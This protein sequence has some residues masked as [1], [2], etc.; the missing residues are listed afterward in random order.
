MFRPSIIW[1]AFG[2]CLAV[3]VAAVGWLSFRALEADDAE[4][5]A[6]HQAALEENAQLALWRMDSAMAP[7][8]AQESARPYFTY[9]SFYSIARPAA[10]TKGKVQAEARVASPLLV[11]C[12]PEVLLH[13][14][15][16]PNH[17]FSSPRVPDP[18]MKARA[19][20]HYLSQADA[21]HAAKELDRV[22]SLIQPTESGLW[23]SLPS[24]DA[25]ATGLN[26]AMANS[27][28]WNSSNTGSGLGG[29]I[30]PAANGGM[31]N[32]LVPNG[33]VNNGIATNPTAPSR[34]VPN[35][36][37]G[38]GGFANAPPNEAVQSDPSQPIQSPL[39]QA[40]TPQQQANSS[41]P[42]QQQAG[43]QPYANGPADQTYNQSAAMQQETRGANEYQARSQYL[44]QNFQAIANNPPRFDSPTP[45]VSPA[46][47]ARASVMKP[48]WISDQLFLMRRVRMND[49]DY[50]QGCLL[51]W[52]AIQRQLLASVQDLLPDAKLS[53]VTAISASEPAHMLASLPVRLELGTLAAAVAE[54]ISPLR[55]SLVG[56]WAAMVLAALAVAAL[57]Q[58][59]LSLSERR[60]A[61]V[62]AVTHE[63]RTPLTT[64]RMYA[65]MLASNMVP[66]EASRHH[67]LETLRVEADRLTHLV[68]NV[69]LYARLERG[70]P[71]GRTAPV[72]VARI[73]EQA[74][75]RLTDRARQANLEIAVEAN[76][77]IREGLVLADLAAVEQILFNLVDNACKYAATATDRTL[78]LEARGSGN[79]V[80]LLLRD[81][82]PGIAAEQR[83]V[84][85]QP[86]R[87]SARDAA[88]SAPGVGLG[89]AL[90]RRLARDMGGELSYAPDASG[91]ACFTLRL[92]V[93]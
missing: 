1:L 19:I 61:F 34:I 39:Q 85:F 16:G 30:G 46:S 36:V 64:F 35:G 48:L 31:N 53:P 24:L 90:C 72:A 68:E 60:G 15:I 52:P 93:A 70:R 3:V 57:L 5:A 29:A 8:V 89:L 43:V 62:S 23:A 78:H 67:Y 2:V 51:D 13:F 21:E 25:S 7:L 14:Q 80:E 86:F 74:T 22:R 71:G 4:V 10:P 6:R 83:R 84:L 28:P 18:A 73:L 75:G 87:K 76:D 12:P 69:L 40:A 92:R 54:G 65:E 44:A 91:G 37:L 58:G 27:S 50:I 33:S 77:A 38:N 32:T 88:H 63:L 47:D 26:I 66:D 20:P 81:H 17:R 11:E 55:M 49:Q 9:E 79:H 59:V 45:G 41:Q 56:A 82:G 42:T